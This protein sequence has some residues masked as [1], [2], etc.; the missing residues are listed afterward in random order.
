MLLAAAGRLFGGTCRLEPPPPAILFTLCVTP[1]YCLCLFHH[2]LLHFLPAGRFCG[3]TSGPVLEMFVPAVFDL[4]VLPVRCLPHNIHLQLLADFV[5][6][7][8]DLPVPCAPY[9]C[10]CCI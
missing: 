6:G 7:P 10:P 1:L 5:E 4:T 2:H 8:F 9:V 3:G